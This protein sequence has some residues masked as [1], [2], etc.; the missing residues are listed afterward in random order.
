MRCRGTV[1]GF[2]SRWEEVKP[3]G[4]PSGNPSIML[5]KIKAYTIEVQEMREESAKLQKVRVSY[6][7]C[8]ADCVPS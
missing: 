2:A 3:K 7:Q 8:F 4:G 5:H 6:A 1:A